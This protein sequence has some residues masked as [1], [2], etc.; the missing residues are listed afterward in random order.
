MEQIAAWIALVADAIKDY[1]LPADQQS[2]SAALRDFR[3]AIQE[4][5]HL[6]ALRADVREFCLK[7]PV[8]GT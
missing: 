2:R 1:R 6:E 4:N 3:R 7:F 5:R 8:A